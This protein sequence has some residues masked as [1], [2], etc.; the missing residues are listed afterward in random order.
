VARAYFP[1]SPFSPFLTLNETY[2]LSYLKSITDRVDYTSLISF[3]IFVAGTIG[4]ENPDLQ[5]NQA[6]FFS[7]SAKDKFSPKKFLSGVSVSNGLGW[8]K[9][10]TI[11]FYID[12][13]TRNIDAFDFDLQRGTISKLW[14][15]PLV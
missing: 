3:N 8:T 11:M 10:D 2:L 14:T 7:F 12:S 4:P 5:P 1:L 15:L 9:N 6:S 13:P